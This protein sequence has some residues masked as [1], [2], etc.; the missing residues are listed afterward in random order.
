MNS[1]TSVFLIFPWLNSR[2]AENKFSKE[3]ISSK[4]F[5][6]SL[7]I[8]NLCLLTLPPPQA[9]RNFDAPLVHKVCELYKKVY[10]LSSKVP[11]QDR[12]GIYLKI[13]NLGLEIACLVIEAA[14]E[15]RSNKLPILNSVR[16]KAEIMKR[17]V[18]IAYELKIIRDKQYL[19]FESDLIEI[20]K[21]TNGW[22]RFLK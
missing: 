9:F 12:F 4:I 15:M 11:K 3:I 10:L 22:I 14:F 6:F 19:E 18:R 16:I 13:E 17:L 8:L 20:S 21:M 5:N 2:Q 1:K 7:S